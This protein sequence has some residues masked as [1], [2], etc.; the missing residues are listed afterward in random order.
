MSPF[1]LFTAQGFADSEQPPLFVRCKFF[2][3]YEAVFRSVMN[4]KGV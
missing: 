1:P 2:T 4:N 3:Y